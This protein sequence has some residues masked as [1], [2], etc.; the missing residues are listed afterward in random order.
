MKG[1]PG[2]MAVSDGGGQV[3]IWRNRK[4]GFSRWGKGRVRGC[5]YD[6][7][8]SRRRTWRLR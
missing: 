6:Q 5:T 7:L 3:L 4:K 2:A 1:F 8:Y